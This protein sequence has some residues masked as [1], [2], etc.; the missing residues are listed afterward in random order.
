MVTVNR[1]A[2]DAADAGVAI[3]A[4]RPRTTIAQ[5]PVEQ[6][7]CNEP[8][9]DRDRVAQALLNGSLHFRAGEESSD[10]QDWNGQSLFEVARVAE[11]VA[12]ARSPDQVAHQ[13][14]QRPE[15][16]EQNSTKPRKKTHASLHHVAQATTERS[17]H[18]GEARLVVADGYFHGIQTVALANKKE[19]VDAMAPVYAKFASDPKLAALVKRIQETK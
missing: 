12:F 13:R 11:I 8:A 9:P 1:L 6:W 14:E 19:F 10:A 16:G 2:A 15:H 5:L 4:P 17:A 7:I 3:H 18:D